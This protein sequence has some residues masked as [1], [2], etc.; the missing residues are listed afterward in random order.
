[1][2]GNPFVL[3]LVRGPDLCDRKRELEDLTSHAQNGHNVILVSPRQYGKSS[4]VLEA[5]EQ[6]RASGFLTVYVDLLAIASDSDVPRKL[7]AAL[8]TDLGRGADPV[9]LAKRVK[10]LFSRIVPSIDFTPTGAT[11]SI[12]LAQDADPIV[13][14]TDVLDSMY[15]YVERQKVRACVV[16]DEFQEIGRLPGSRTIEATFRSYLQDRRNISFFFVGSRRQA[17]TEMFTRA[18]PLYQTAY[19]TPLERILREDFVPYITERFDR[20]GKKCSPETAGL[21]YDRV[22]GYPAYVQR[23]AGAAWDL[24]SLTCTK[25]KIENAYGSLLTVAGVEFGSTWISLPLGQRTLLQAL[26]AE[27]TTQLTS[28]D[29]LRRHGLVASTVQRA[30]KPLLELDLVERTPATG[31]FFVV[32]PML[33]AWVSRSPAIEL[34]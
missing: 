20:T 34:K 7:A 8:V 24:S 3:G 30:I 11:V 26:A 15:R 5:Q 14:L 17:L 6:L 21:I 4:L 25:E 29:Y 12:G 1:M 33:A 31:R 28:A 9:T 23:L 19:L 32:D 10:N 18:R 22:D 2:V 16:L 27:S 13:L